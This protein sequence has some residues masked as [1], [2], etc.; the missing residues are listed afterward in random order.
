MTNLA[1]SLLGGAALLALA[2]APAQAALNIVSVVGGAPTGATLFNFDALAVGTGSPQV[3]TGTGGA[4]MTV[5]LT[6]DAR[7][8]NGSL[9]GQYAAPFLSGNNGNGFGS[10]NQ[11]NGADTTNYL[12]SGRDASPNAGASVA[13]QLGGDY[14]YFG[15]LWGSVDAYNTLSF[16]D[17]GVLVGSLTG[18]A[19]TAAA[20]GDQGANGTFYVNIN[21]SLDFDTVVATSS[22]YAFEF[23]NVAISRTAIPEPAS[24]A[25]LGLGLIGLGM[26][27][28]AKRRA[29]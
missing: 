8:A 12:T 13:L 19:V 18:S 10:P 6:P 22:Q 16:Y 1:K 7:V 23:D 25:L 9:S 26:A 20:N 29:G 5:V 2:G 3:A 21:S 24:L 11:P 27:G 28:R 17:N 4:T 15:L 14:R